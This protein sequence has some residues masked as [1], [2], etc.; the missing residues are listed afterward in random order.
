MPRERMPSKGWHRLKGHGTRLVPKVYED[1]SVADVPNVMAWNGVTE[2]KRDLVVV[3]LYDYSPEVGP[4]FHIESFRRPSHAEAK[5]TRLQFGDASKR[6][7]VWDDLFAYLKADGIM[8][9]E[10]NE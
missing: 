5:F 9:E 8:P 7:A 1:G 4:C 2:W 6:G 10:A 3:R